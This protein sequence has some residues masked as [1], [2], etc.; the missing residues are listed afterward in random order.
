MGV[1]LFTQSNILVLLLP[2][3]G[4]DKGYEGEEG[5]VGLRDQYQ[6]QPFDIAIVFPFFCLVSLF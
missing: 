6:L 3:F 2:R 1:P 4:G 5:S